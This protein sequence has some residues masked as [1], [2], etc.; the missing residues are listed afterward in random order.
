LGAGLG[1]ILGFV[2]G[3]FVFGTGGAAIGTVLGERLGGLLG[4]TAAGEELN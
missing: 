2:L 4:L 1:K 3:L